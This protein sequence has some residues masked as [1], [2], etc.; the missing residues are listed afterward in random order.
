MWMFVHTEARD[1]NCSP[2]IYGSCVSHL[3]PELTYMVSS[4]TELVPSMVFLYLLSAR[5]QVGHI[6]A[7]HFCARWWPKLQLSHLHTSPLPA[8]PSPRPSPLLLEIILTGRS[9]CCQ[10]LENNLA[11]QIWPHGCLLVCVVPN[12]TVAIVSFLILENIVFLLTL[13][14]FLYFLF[15]FCILHFVYGVCVRET[16]D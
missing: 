16:Q 15:V 5:C 13:A 9:L 10:V 2:P 4:A 6:P 7:Q 8:T 11:L 14:G 3:N 12:K 1:S